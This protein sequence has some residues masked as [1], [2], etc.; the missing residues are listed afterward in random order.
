MQKRVLIADD[1]KAVR[2]TLKDVLAGKEYLV[3]TVVNGYELLAYIKE[4][5]PNIII[6]DLIMPEKGG[7]DIIFSIKKIAPNTKVIIYTGYSKYEKSIYA[8]SADSF[9]VK[10][11]SIE[12]L[13]RIIDI[14]S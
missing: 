14:L 5:I 1:N 2:D 11:E 9:I 3:D 13:L 7:L 4:T 12:N 8:E 10:G 6:L